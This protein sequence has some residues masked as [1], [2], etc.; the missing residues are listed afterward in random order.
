[1]LLWLAFLVPEMIL[2][3]RC[4]GSGFLTAALLTALPAA[5]VTFV[6][7]FLKA[8]LVRRL[9]GGTAALALYLLAAS[10][11]VYYRIFGTFYTVYSLTNGV[12]ALQF[13]H[14]IRSALLAELP[15]L[16]LMALPTAALCFLGG[17]FPIPDRRRCAVGL[18]LGA[19]VQAAAVLSLPL[20]GGTGDTSPYGLYHRGTDTALSVRSL[21]L[22]TTFRL[23]LQRQLTGQTAGGTIVLESQP[24]QT[25]APT[26]TAP[27]APTETAP[28][29]SAP[30]ETAPAETE[31]TEPPVD[32][33][34]NVLALDLDALAA[35][36]DSQELAKVHAY[37]ASRTP[38]EKNEYTGLFEGCNLILITAEAFSHLAVSEELTP[39][40]YKLTHEGVYFSN[41]YVPDWGVSTTDGEYAFLTGT[42]PKNGVWSFS[43]SSD[44]SM[45]LTMNRQLQALGYS[46]YA[47][48]GHTYDYYDRDQYLTN[49]GYDYK[50]YGNGLDVTWQ[51]P[52]SDVE[53]VD[54]STGDFVSQEPFSVYYMSI[55]GHREFNF[56]GN[57]MAY[58]NREAVAD[59][60]YSEA[61]R[62]YL[63]CQL[64]LENSLTLLL[65]RLE[66][67]GVL[68]NT[69]I[70][71]TADHYP[72][73]LTAEELGELLGHTPEGNF[74]LF[75]NGCILYKP[76]M[77]PVTVEEPVSHLDLLPTLS[78]LFGL[79][80]DSRLYMGRD[81]FSGANPLI[82]F[83][84]R[85][86]ITDKAM[87]N[88][89]TG[90]V[91]ALTEEPVTDEY[92]QAISREVS[93]RCAVSARILEYDYWR[94]LFE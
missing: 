2:L 35:E 77:E 80:Y 86:W 59:L 13:V 81:V 51:W 56:M 12:G 39:T 44:N 14:T 40:L 87:F 48:H 43:R 31:P 62:A 71:L 70:C 10:Q 29:V 63:A 72:N 52:E 28:A 73:G 91:T 23:D 49:L 93:N 27:A 22:F 5:A 17:R 85:S 94:I 41:Y 54:L 30:T 53:V 38:T 68:E 67:A 57:S 64:E 69:V 33:S 19:A 1:M 42:V 75:R 76:G 79:E 65:Q 58:K 11:L 18:A 78:N 47:Y 34:P 83:R 24:A 20:W 15:W 37:F 8:P 66:E 4:G 84:N 36:A 82:F 50:A 61:V 26:E 74:E 16:L 9:L 92:V 90:E 46:S 45:P 21:G 55:S 6:C 25:A 7:G 3:L 32:R 89:E 88:A 60:P